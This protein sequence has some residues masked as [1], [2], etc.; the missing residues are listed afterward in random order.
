MGATER[1]S[2]VVVQKTSSSRCEPPLRAPCRHADR[3]TLRILAEIHRVTAAFLDTTAAE[4]VVRSPGQIWLSNA[5]GPRAFD[6][7]ILRD[8]RL[9]SL[10]RMRCSCYEALML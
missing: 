3:N 5:C 6:R 8:A 7:F 1:R 4:A 10:L 9:R 2:P